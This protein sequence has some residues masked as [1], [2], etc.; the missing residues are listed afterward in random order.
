[1]YIILKNEHQYI[2]NVLQANLRTSANTRT[3][4]THASKRTYKIYFPKG[5]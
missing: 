3:S 5:L 2:P 1:M 4:Q